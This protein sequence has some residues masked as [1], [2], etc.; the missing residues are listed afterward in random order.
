[1]AAIEARSGGTKDARALVAACMAVAGS[2]ASCIADEEVRARL[3]AGWINDFVRY[4]G[5]RD[6]TPDQDATRQAE[7]VYLTA[8]SD[9][10][11]DYPH[12]VLEEPVGVAFAVAV[13]SDDF[14]RSAVEYFSAYLEKRAAA[15]GRMN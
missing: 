11:C 15:R 3:V 5:I 8:C 14:C 12:L 9:P 4:T 2:Y 6:Q 10:E 1:M 13:L 7:Y